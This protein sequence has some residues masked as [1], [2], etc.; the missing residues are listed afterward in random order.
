MNLPMHSGYEQLVAKARQSHEQGRNS[1]DITGEDIA[2]A[3]LYSYAFRMHTIGAF[4]VTRLA[5][6]ALEIGDRGL[7]SGG[8]RG[9]V[10]TS[11]SRAQNRG[12]RSVSR[13]AVRRRQG[14]MLCEL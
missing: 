4:H 2:L 8:I 9:G 10:K 7:E 6:E 3:R 13:P 11:S 12:E 14:S 1:L 5:L